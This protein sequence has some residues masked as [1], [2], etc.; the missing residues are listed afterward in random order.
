MMRPMK[1]DLAAWRA[2][3]ERDLKGAPLERLIQRTDDGVAVQPLY[4]EAEG[5]LPAARAPAARPRRLT[6]AAHPDAAVRA[7]WIAE[8]LARG[9]EAVLLDASDLAPADLATLLAAVPA[10]VPVSLAHADAD[11]AAALLAAR[12]DAPAGLGISPFE[13]AAAAGQP[14][15]LAEGVELARRAPGWRVFE[16]DA[17]AWH[18]AGAGDAQQIA[19]ALAS[20]VGCLRALD[21]VP[22]PAA[23]LGF[24][25]AVGTRFFEAIATLRA[26][27]ACWARVLEVSG[28]A[29]AFHL[30]A[31]PAARQWTRHE[32][33]VN[34]L[35]G[36]AMAFAAQVGGADEVVGVPLDAAL[37]PA[38]DVGRRL[39]R[40]TP[41]ILDAEGHLG[42]VA[43]PAGG[44]FFLET[45]TAEIAERAWAGF[46]AIE[47]QGGLAAALAAGTVQAGLAEISAQRAR[48]IARRQQ[49]VVGVTAYPVIEPPP[50]AAAPSAP[51]ATE[52]P[53]F[54]P[55]VFRQDVSDFEGLRST[56]EA[57]ARGGEPARVGL[58]R[59]GP[60]ARHLARATFAT[61]LL[62]AGGVDAVG[63]A[64]PADPVAAFV[65][66]GATVACLCGHDD[67]Y[68][69]DAA[70]VAA[71]LKAAGARRV[72]L[73]GKP[74]AAEATWRA[75][76][77]DDFIYLGCDAV[78]ALQGVLAALA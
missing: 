50:E 54:E 64:E 20:G 14:P 68:A 58:V 46:Q 61:H 53:A 77:V 27:R 8:D 10:G 36:T 4:T 49:G 78:A 32:P 43:D 3:V 18:A 33:F 62:A 5:T 21:G 52:A 48:R 47:A 11:L 28:L 71:G 15:R 29:P 41:L 17:H 44:S 31:R 57:L 65:A 34:L 51:Q 69:T 37:G 35:R 26:L 2:L 38:G 42:R 25:V 67:D 59:L 60:L 74:G 9:A 70:A 66:S 55:L 16:V 75:A 30:R 76:G 45:L 19:L 7:R 72:L 63:E 24:T 40:N 23:R 56:A 22:D 12:P 39:A 73:A 6:A 1:P 13:A